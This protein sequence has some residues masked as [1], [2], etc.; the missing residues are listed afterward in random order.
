MVGP[1]ALTAILASDPVGR[2]LFEYWHY[3][4]MGS[5]RPAAAEDL[6]DVD[7]QNGPLFYALKGLEA[8][9]TAEGHVSGSMT[10]EYVQ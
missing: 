9:L 2:D 7:W 5:G 1:T 8:L 4:D 6:F 10:R 3:E